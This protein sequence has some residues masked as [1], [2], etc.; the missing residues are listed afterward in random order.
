MPRQASTTGGAS[1]RRH[2]LEREAQR[3]REHHQWEERAVHRG[4]HRIGRHHVD[5][6]L[7]ER[8]HRGGG[9]HR[10][11]RAPHAFRHLGRH[12]E[13]RE[14]E[15]RRHERERA[16]GHEQHDENDERP[17]AGAPQLGAPAGPR[18]RRDRQRRDE[19]EDRHPDGIRPERAHHVGGGQ[20]LRGHRREAA[21]RWIRQS[22]P[23]REPR[24]ECQQDLQRL[25]LQHPGAPRLSGASRA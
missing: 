16:A 2:L 1:F 23:E 10:R 9:R 24:R 19:R 13:A 5:E 8:G 4:L 25:A 6:P 7:G 20:G 14:G 11:H 22:H 12:G 3:Q 15:L 21:R 18:H 17:P